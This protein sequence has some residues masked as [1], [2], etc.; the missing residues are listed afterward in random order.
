MQVVVNFLVIMFSVA[1]GYVADGVDGIPLFVILA[2][3][4]ILLFQVEK[5]TR[6]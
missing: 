3:I 4:L 2:I 5:N 6:K 1:I